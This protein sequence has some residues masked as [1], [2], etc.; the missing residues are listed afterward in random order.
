MLT[1]FQILVVVEPPTRKLF[2]HDR[3]KLV[4]FRVVCLQLHRIDLNG[5]VCRSICWGI[6]RE[7]FKAL[8]QLVSDFLQLHLLNF[9]A[10]VGH[11]RT[12]NQLIKQLFVLC[13]E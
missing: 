7:L 11:D 10:G 12:L 5:L 3:F 1:L 2:Y 9:E 13:L 8:H 6:D 4:S